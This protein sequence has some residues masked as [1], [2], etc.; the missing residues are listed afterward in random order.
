MP[1]IGRW[2]GIDQLAEKYLSTGTYTYVANNPVSNADVDGRWFNDDGSIDTSGTANGFVRTR[3]YTQSYLG[4]YP[5]QGGGGPTPKNN[6]GTGLVEIL[7]NFFNRLFGGSKGAEIDTFAEGATVSRAVQVGDVIPMGEAI[8]TWEEVMATAGVLG[9]G[10]WGLPLILNGDSSFHANSKPLAMPVD[11]PVTTTGEP[12][13]T[14]T[15]YRGVS[16]KAKG[17]MYF[18]AMQG[19]AI[20]NGFRQ[21]STMWGPHSDMGAHAM[22]DNYSIWTSWSSDR[23][24]AKNFATGVAFGKAVPGI[25][26]S[27]TFRVGQAVPNPFSMGESEWLVP[28][29]TFGARVQYVLPRSGQ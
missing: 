8:L 4:Q 15:L 28:G 13:P 5:G 11:I 27:K 10:L 3:S 23:E 21:V 1:D 24:M 7:S 6:S 25:I 29:V 26:M 12:E 16:S 17:S 20:P 18:E 2:N 14:I 22:G 9:R 19:I